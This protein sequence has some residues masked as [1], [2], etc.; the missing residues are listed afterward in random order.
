MKNKYF[1]RKEFKDI[2]NKWEDARANGDGIYLESDDLI[3]I[4]EYYHQEG[5]LDLSKEA[6]D[7]AVQ[8]FPGST[9]PLVFRARISLLVDK[10]PIT[11]TNY[12][13]LVDDKS[14]LDYYYLKAEILI[15]QMH[16][17]EANEYLKLQL[18]NI[19]D[20]ED[21]EDYYIDVTNLFA[22]YEC[23]E[24]AIEWLNLSHETNSSDYLELKGRIAIGTEHYKEGEEIY[25]KL[26]DEAPFNGQYW[27]Q[28]AESQLMHNKISD[29]IQSSEYSI[30][31]DPTDFEA[32]LNKG[33]GLYHLGNYEEALKY[34]ERFKSL[35]P[36]EEIGDMFIGFALNGLKKYDEAISH[37]IV[38]EKMADKSSPNLLEI[39]RNMAVSYSKI[40]K[41]K[42]AIDCINKIEAIDND[43]VSAL[44]QK[45]SI[46]MENELIKE[47][48]EAYI[49]AL[50]HADIQPIAFIHIVISI[51]KN[52]NA[53][54][55]YNI[56]KSLF[57]AVENQDWKLGYSYI[58]LCARQLD[59]QDEFLQY[60]QKAI[61]VNPE[62]AQEMFKD[63]CP[64][65]MKVEQMF[66]YFQNNRKGLSNNN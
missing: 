5:R 9:A 26:I 48:K 53:N 29:S 25:E 22:D 30:A 20:E 37:F 51:Q 12:A 36:N 62:E 23:W 54:T 21:R 19:D 27:N 31:I 11:A 24:Y 44:T 17:T 1:E 38:A 57:D 60:A 43:Q 13:E 15:Y 66:E 28:L 63:I 58:A 8:L 65:G 7:Y 46:Y 39:Y 6:V 35:C 64:K 47:S 16:Y 59:F 49:D 42:E 34:Y 56:L 3:D 41:V 55:A 50:Q 14:D 33:N 45:G 10:D 18:E 40:G 2:L 61:E 32:I 52:K 4:A